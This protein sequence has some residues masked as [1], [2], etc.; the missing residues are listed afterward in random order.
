[1]R[2]NNC[3]VIRQELDELMLG[4]TFSAAATEHLRECAECR[5]F[6]EKQTG[7]RLIVGSLG[8]VSAPPDFDFRLRARLANDANSAA[9]HFWPLARR[10]L[11][12]AAVLL[13]LVLGA[14]LVRNVFYRPAENKQFATNEP[15]QTTPP[16]QPAP[17]VEHR[18]SSHPIPEVV[19]SS[20]D[21]HPQVIRNERSTGI[22]RPLVAEDF[23]SE[24]APVISSQEPSGTFEVLPLDSSLQSFKVSLDD[25]RGNARTI[26]VPTISFG[27]QRMLQTGN[28]YASKRDW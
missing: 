4:E 20:S 16:P 28:Q 8:T 27:S 3:E 13:V 6:N 24:R 14:I 15:R 7:L 23:S 21:R 17:A 5:E 25:G 18:E 12:F 19:A 9:F 26:S 1:M 2:K 10:G 22:R 11:A